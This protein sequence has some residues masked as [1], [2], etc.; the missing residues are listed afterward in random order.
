MFLIY[1]FILYVYYVIIVFVHN[2]Y[3]CNGFIKEV[4]ILLIRVILYMIIGYGDYL[5]LLLVIVRDVNFLSVIMRI[6]L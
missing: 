2:F 6:G 3:E 5:L 4:F 1:Q